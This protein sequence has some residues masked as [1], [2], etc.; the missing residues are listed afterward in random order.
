MQLAGAED[1]ELFR[2]ERRKPQMLTVLAQRHRQLE[3]RRAER[4]WNATKPELVLAPASAE[5]RARAP[6]RQA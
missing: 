4:P 3:I 6:W 5:L 2:R 1:G